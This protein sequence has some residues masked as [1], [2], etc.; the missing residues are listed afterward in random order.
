MSRIETIQTCFIRALEDILVKD[1]HVAVS[2]QPFGSYLYM[3]LSYRDH[4]VD[5]E[6]IDLL[7]TT[8]DAEKSSK[9]V[10]RVERALRKRSDIATIDLVLRKT[11]IPIVKV[12]SRHYPA[13]KVDLVINSHDGLQWSNLLKD[14]LSSS[15]E[16]AVVEAC[17][18]LVSIVKAWAKSKGICGASVGNLSSFGFVVLCV[19][20]LQHPTIGYIP[21]FR[22]GIPHGGTT[23]TRQQ[24]IIP[25]PQLTLLF[26]EWLRSFRLQQQHD[27]VIFPTLNWI[28]K[29]PESAAKA[30]VKIPKTGILMYDNMVTFRNIA[31]ATENRPDRVEALFIAINKAIIRLQN[32]SPAINRTDLTTMLTRETNYY[33]G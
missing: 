17:C 12:S 9:T 25:L 2:V 8:S 5:Y 29:P 22:Q 15:Q 32:I 23:T 6:D 11:R 16:N 30:T 21:Q 7:V 20:F 27:L 14:A 26:F 24:R 19:Q 33:S 13:L 28:D 31:A 18:S 10:S 4:L 1:S 3:P